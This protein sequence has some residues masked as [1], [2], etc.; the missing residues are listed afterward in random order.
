MQCAPEFGSRAC[1]DPRIVC[2][3][4]TKCRGG[5]VAL[6]PLAGIRVLELG[7]FIAGP[8][9]GQ[10][11]ADYGA[12]VIKVEPPGRGDPMR[13]WGITKHGTSLWWHAIARNKRSVTIDL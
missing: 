6:G 4:S 3:I 12:D 1:P 13:A 7:S 10:L 5:V 9:A 11:L 8:F 2:N